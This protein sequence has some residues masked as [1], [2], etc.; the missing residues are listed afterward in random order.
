MGEKTTYDVDDEVRKPRG[1]SGVEWLDAV[2]KARLMV[3]KLKEQRQAHQP[4]V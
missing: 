2:E 4:K 1:R 3:T